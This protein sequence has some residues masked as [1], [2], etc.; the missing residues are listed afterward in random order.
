MQIEK[1]LVEKLKEFGLK[2]LEAKTYLTLLKIGESSVL[3][4]AKAADVHRRSVYDNVNIL[5]RKGLVIERVKG[6]TKIYKALGPERLQILIEEKQSILDDMSPLLNKV[7]SGE[8]KEVSVEVVRGDKSFSH[9][10]QDVIS[11]KKQINW[12]GG[13]GGVSGIFFDRIAHKREFV[14]SRVEKL[15]VYAVQPINHAIEGLKASTRTYKALSGKIRLL[16]REFTS[17]QGIII[18]GDKVCIGIIEEI[19]FTGILIKSEVSA[20]AFKMY[21]DALWNIA[22]PLTDELMDKYYNAK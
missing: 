15:D 18:Y 11:S 7:I 4:I 21:F 8:N 19:D 2:D 10:L 5:L 6:K 1:S 17:N 14:D 22:E 3:Q 16:P 20:K 13:G 12:I 9:I